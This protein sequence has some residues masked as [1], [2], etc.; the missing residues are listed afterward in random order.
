MKHFI[1][2]AMLLLMIAMIASS[3]GSKYNYETVK[4]DPLKT[5]IYTLD[6]GLKVYM[7]VNQEQP[8][9]QTYVAVKVGG[10]NDPSETTGLAHYFEHLMFK[11]TQSFGTQNYEAEKPL[12]DE[13][14][15]LFEVYRQTTDSTERAAI[16]H[17]IDSVSQEA[18]KLSIPNEYDKLMAAIGASGTNAWTSFDETV[19]TEDIPSNQIENWAKIQADRFENNVIRGF[20]TELETV[21][22]EKNMSLTN[23][24]RKV[25]EAMYAALYP[26]HPYG[27]QTVLGTQEHLK[28][29]SITNIKNYHKTYYVP[30]NMAICLSGDFNPDTMISIVD[31]YFG[32]LKPNNNLPKLTFEQE[33]PITEPVE[34]EV[35]GLDAQNVRLAWRSGSAASNDA[36]MTQMIGDILA[37]GKAG[38][39]DVDLMQTQKVLS[40]SAY[41]S[42]MADYGLLSMYGRPKA[43]Q[44][45][46]E[47]K[48]L[49]LAELAKLRNGDF[50]EGLITSTVANYKLQ[51]QRYMDSNSGRA[52]AFVN[53]FI[54]G[55]P[56]E[57]MVNELDRM[58][59]ITKEEIV[60]FANERFTD[61]NYVVIYKR[62][63]KDPNE[64]K[65][66]KPKITPIATNRDAESAFFTEIQNTEVQPIAPVF[67]DYEKD[68][69][70]LKAKNNIEVLYKK[71]ETTDLF[72]LM[73][74][75]EIG[76]N[77]DPYSNM[78]FNYMKYLETGTKTLEE[79]NRQFYDIACS[80]N[81]SSAAERSYIVISGLNENMDQ[82]MK[83]MEEIFADAQPNETALENLK[84]DMLKKRS[85]AKKN[86][87]SNFSALRRY[88]MYGSECVKATTLTD[89]QILKVTSDELLK[90]IKNLVTLEHRVLYYG[91][92]T[93]EEVVAK[94]NEIHNTPE[95]LRP[96]ENRIQYI[97]LQTPENQVLMAE[98]D[99]KQ[100]RFIQ[101]TNNGEKFD[102]AKEP[103]GTM[104][105]QYFGGS[106]S[107]IVFQEMRE[108][109][110]LAYSASAYFSE[111]S[112]LND[113]YT[114][115]AFIATQND[116]MNDALDAFEEIINNMPE[117]EKAFEVSKA[118]LLANYETQRT[119]KADVLW[120]Y[121]DAQDLG[122]NY[123]RRKNNY[124]AIKNFTLADVVKF[125]QENIKNRT[126]T[127][128]ILGHI[129]DLDLKKLNKIST[130]KILSQEEIFGY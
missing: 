69:S 60:K 108:A 106:M 47:V 39:I 40:A 72:S 3:C 77:N 11:G 64:Q 12:L 65:I 98:Y 35:F 81:V 52:R 15:R 113:T 24:G 18:S 80:F 103:I 97:P 107:S 50:D 100:I 120:S 1:K 90:K 114:F 68:M 85:D 28:N 70:I 26:N 34:K 111:P 6:N 21:Y 27:K 83:L 42:A 67:L 58:S 127:Y 2:S 7:T 8:R 104:Y 19:Y 20:H 119:V 118:E 116:K 49:L 56:W 4:N 92:S 110:G 46:E 130:I 44:T 87:G 9:I 105:Q 13:I 14:E 112:D 37:N 53:S 55:I 66:S 115:I 71:N 17:Q 126:Y 22:E 5:R 33:Q 76:N 29:P 62:E 36:M 78:A 23:D 84:M 93:G 59:K 86:Q 63:G 89:E 123:D 74:V 102:A 51:Q 73:Y 41:G 25:N 88:A 10:K 95:T 16:Y 101:L 94:I 45:L 38:L 43:G 31:K 109:R 91:K 48:D 121:I 122:L 124:E 82:A 99:A 79:I 30:N 117:S 57:E 128:C 96:I 32:Q 125:Q 75:F 61:N 129:K 54:D